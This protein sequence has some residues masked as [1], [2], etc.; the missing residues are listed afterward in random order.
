[1][2]NSK[3]KKGFTLIELLVVIAIISLLSAIIF[4]SLNSARA[5][6]RDAQRR[7]DI[8]QLQI[9]L[10]LYFD[11][12]GVYP[13]SGGAANPNASWSNSAESTTWNSGSLQTALAPYI[14]KLP[15][16]PLNQIG[17]INNVYYY[18]RLTGYS[19]NS[20]AYLLVYKLENGASVISPGF[21]TCD[22]SAPVT[23]N[24]NNG[25]TPPTLNISSASGIITVGQKGF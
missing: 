19:C 5:K 22:G 18:V 7:E 17:W 9:A 16:D 4:A 11:S 1:M 10:E 15:T 21:P 24:Y 6:G 13:A 25:N 12:N 3:L 20:K 14:S 23:F 2:K 8:H